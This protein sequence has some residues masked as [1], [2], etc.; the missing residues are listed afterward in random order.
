MIVVQLEEGDKEKRKRETRNEKRETRNEK[1]ET[2]NEI[3]CTNTWGGG[4]EK[5]RG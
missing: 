5:K 1:R 4:R 3:A 2:R